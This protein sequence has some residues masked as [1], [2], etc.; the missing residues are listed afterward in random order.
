MTTKAKCLALAKE[1]DIEIYVHKSWGNE[2]Q[3]QLT[4]PKGYQLEEFEG[5]RTGLSMSGIYGAKELWKE[6]YSD[7]KTMIN[8]KPWFKVSEVEGGK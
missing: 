7:L 3:T 4:V 1:H 5:A 2:Y 6:V 8:F